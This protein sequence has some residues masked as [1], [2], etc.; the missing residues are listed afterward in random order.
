MPPF[1]FRLQDAVA[2]AVFLGVS[3][4]AAAL[5]SVATSSS[6]D[7]WY[8]NLDK[9]SWTPPG[10]LIGTVWSIL[11][12]LMGIAAWI[13]WRQVGWTLSL[14]LVLF[15]IQLG[16]N[17]LWSVVFFGLQNPAAGFVTIIV[18]WVAVLTTL[19]VFWQV[20]P[21]AGGLFVPYIAWVTF[22]GGLNFILWQ[23][24]L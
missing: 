7:P 22:A 18:L 5:G 13:V 3:F 24:N 19:V 4:I 23:M 12:T 17:V 16:L 14:P 1:E 8:A 6:L 15:G 10:S 21:L 2:L 9:P 11:Y 20:A